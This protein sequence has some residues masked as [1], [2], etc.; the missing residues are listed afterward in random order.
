VTRLLP[1]SGP[2]RWLALANLVST[3]GNGMYFTAGVLYFTRAVGLPANSVGL[4]MSVAGL[5]AM[6]SG[7]V[8]G[9]WADRRGPRGVYALTLLG[10]AA[11][12]GGFCLVR[13]FWPFLVVA[14]LGAAAQA[15]GPR[16]RAPIIRQFGGDNPQAFRA[17]LQAVTNLG[18]VAGALIAGWAIQQDTH[19]AYLIMIAANAVSFLL[20]ALIVFKVPAIRPEPVAA[21]MPRWIALRD[22]RYVALTVLD[23][24]LAVQ[25][26]VI[27]IALP[28][29]VLASPVIPRW[30]VAGA[31][32]ANAVIVTLFQVRASRGIDS[33][34]AGARAMRRAGLAFLVSCT[35]IAVADLGASAVA[36]VVVLLA[37]GVHTVGGLWHAAGGFE[38]SFR[39]APDHATGQYVGLFGLGMTLSEAVAPLLLTAL[40]IGLGRPGWLILGAI[41]ATAGLLCPIVT[42]FAGQVSDHVPAHAAGRTVA[43]PPVRRG[44][45]YPTALQAPR[46]GSAGG[47]SPGRHR[48]VAGRPVPGGG[49]QDSPVLSSR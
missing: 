11:A 2:Q 32:V 14:V 47:P 31:S 24:V 37:V 15:A 38:V 40:C 7:L 23:G 4:G 42:R 10:G 1:D 21:G 16:T 19:R 49:G 27:T 46:S 35:L 6:A 26:R 18:V 43:S 36:A 5:A 28:L 3:V 12:M 13:G 34:H 20:S 39:L 29:W 30:L 22:R 41:L 33:P 8:V 25:Y 44:G 17:Y 48:R 9:H 45:R